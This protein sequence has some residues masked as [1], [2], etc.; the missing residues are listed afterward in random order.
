MTTV[1]LL[2]LDYVFT[3]SASEPITFAFAF[4]EMIDPEQLKLAL[5][6]THKHFPL[7]SGKLVE[8][9]VDR[10]GYAGDDQPGTLAVRESDCAFDPDHDPS[11]YVESV[12][13]KA[14]QPLSRL[15]LTQTPGGSVLAVSMSHALAD[16][17][18]YLHFLTSWARLARG[19]R[20]LPPT[21]ERQTLIHPTEALDSPVTFSGVSETGLFWMK[22]EPRRKAENVR[23][24]RFVLE[25]NFLAELVTEAQSASDIR[26]SQNDVL[27]AY[28]WKEY[29]P[30][31]CNQE[32]DGETFFTLPVDV[33]RLL[34]WVSRT[35][36]GCALTFA[37]A[38]ITFEELATSS[39]SDLAGCIHRAFSSVTPA[40][41]LASY[42]R[43]SR[44]RMEHGRAAMEEVHIRHPRSGMVLTNIS[45][46]PFKDL[47]FGNGPPESVS[48]Y[49]ELS[50]GV[51]VMPASDGVEIL[52]FR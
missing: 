47:D 43:L 4:S 29:L 44:L 38:T 39:L 26:L 42:E 27:S 17:F 22:G 48:M 45:K 7:V 12:V 14:G 31:I 33:R 40:R 51:A 25:S 24:D 15:Q 46:L 20:I 19:S 36:F 3:E 6:E 13:G 23:R 5:L 18:S 21:G 8:L 41:I 11:H 16:G 9:P 32:Q 49:T 2:P 35:Y 28:L 1:P 30:S 50:G 34:P 10:L 52:L 37:T